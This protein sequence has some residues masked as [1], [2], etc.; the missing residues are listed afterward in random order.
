[1]AATSASPA[2][3]MPLQSLGRSGLLVSRLSVGSW[4]TFST[5][6]GTDDAYSLMKSACQVVMWR[7]DLS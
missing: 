3:T 5:Q 4:V 7:L 1:M 2:V 6:V